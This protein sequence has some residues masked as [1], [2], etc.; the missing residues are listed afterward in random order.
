VHYP[1]TKAAAWRMSMYM[2]RANR[3][4]ILTLI[5][6]P[7]LFTVA[8]SSSD[9][10]KSNFLPLLWRLPLFISCW[11]LFILGLFILGLT[12]R[13]RNGSYQVSSGLGVDGF[14]DHTKFKTIILPWNK[15]KDIRDYQG[16]LHFWS[17]GANACFI[18]AD[19]FASGEE[20]Q[21]FLET[22]IAL[23]KGTWRPPQPPPTVPS[24]SEFDL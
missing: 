9:L 16:D 20:R 22:A 24:V 10:L 8:A 4:L 7:A 2:L 5:S 13:F 12:Q 18:P 15:I 11:V 3:R 6:T 14:H 19:A 1:I 17:D 21:Q 23:W